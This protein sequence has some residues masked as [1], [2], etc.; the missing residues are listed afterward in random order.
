MHM[1]Q[2]QP[3]AN[4]KRQAFRVDFLC[5]CW[6]FCFFFLF[7]FTFSRALSIKMTIFSLFISFSLI[8]VFFLFLHRRVFI[9]L[10]MVMVCCYFFLSISY[11]LPSFTIHINNRVHNM[12][13]TCKYEMHLLF[14]NICWHAIFR[15]TTQK[16]SYSCTMH[17]C[18]HTPTHS[19]IQ[20]WRFK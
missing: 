1:H 8:L 20:L 18:T 13:G 19:P 7:L 16:H 15:S 11:L 6:L 2:K 9:L 4:R 12:H 14:L 17:S 3:E 10:K 5:C